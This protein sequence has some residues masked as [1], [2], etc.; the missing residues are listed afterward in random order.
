MQN[1]VETDRR[2]ITDEHAVRRFGFALRADGQFRRTS[3][4][5]W[6]C[7]QVGHELLLIGRTDVGTVTHHS[8]DH[9]VPVT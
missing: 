7:V 1:A 2:S 6:S 8:R 3:G 4:L 5:L 9:G